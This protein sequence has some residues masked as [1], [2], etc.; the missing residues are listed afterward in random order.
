MTMNSLSPRLLLCQRLWDDTHLC[1][2]LQVLLV[3][4]HALVLQERLVLVGLQCKELSARGRSSRGTR[5]YPSA[6][7]PHVASAR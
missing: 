6:Q 2:L 1:M 5:G 7:G 3:Q 4:P